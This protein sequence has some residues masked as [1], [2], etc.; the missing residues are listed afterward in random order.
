MFAFGGRDVLRLAAMSDSVAI[1]NAA[2]IWVLAET[3]KLCQS[4][5][6]GLFGG[7]NIFYLAAM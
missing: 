5:I 1:L 2:V 3:K 4:K 7:C 6:W